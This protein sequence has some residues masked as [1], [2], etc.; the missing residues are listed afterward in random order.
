MN[1]QL[2]EEQIAVRDAARNFAKTELLPGVIER[3]EHQK[4]P[5]EQI[6]KLAELG[7]LGMMVSPE[8][9]GSGMDTISYVLA[10]EEISKIDA[11]VSVCMSV[12]NSLVCWGLETFGTEKQKQNI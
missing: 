9:G 3:D 8:Y 1:F 10:M 11:S 4:F 12:N 5:K 6:I 7:F 2:T